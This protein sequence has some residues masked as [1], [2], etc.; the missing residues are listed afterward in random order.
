MGAVY[1]ISV[2]YQAYWKEKPHFIK[3]S[4]NEP[5][6]L[7]FAVEEGR[8]SYEI[9]GHAGEAEGGDIVVCPPNLPFRREMIS[10]LSFHY[11]IFS[12][13]KND[14][15]AERRTIDLLRRLYAFKYT[16]SEQE[17]LY[18]TYRQLHRLMR[19]QD[20]QSKTWLQHFANDIWLLFR[21][22]AESLA[23]Y[24]NLAED[25][26]MKEARAMI[27]HHAFRDIRLQDVAAFLHIH[28]VQLSRRFQ[29]VFGMSPSRYLVS[30]RMEKAKN[31]LVQSEYTIDHIAR[32]CGYENGFY[33]SR[34][35]TAYSKMN[36]SQYRKK[37]SLA[38][39]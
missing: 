29:H 18:N 31:L 37:H 6:W 21:I 12:Y 2:S 14:T 16:A 7:M 32:L 20:E 24:D 10:P 38:S 35:F 5:R 4:A 39:L 3:N 33:F 1:P 11:F 13:D 9:D 28:P 17:R 23:Q 36:P 34:V 25:K 8:F 22:E 30:L 19:L 27:D 15:E 26:L